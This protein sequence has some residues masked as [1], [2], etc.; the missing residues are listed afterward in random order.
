MPVTNSD[1]K[2]TKFRGVTELALLSLTPP[3]KVVV[4]PK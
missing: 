1:L 3:F 2:K 4:D